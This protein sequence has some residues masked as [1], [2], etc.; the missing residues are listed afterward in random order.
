MRV[1]DPR[2][3]NDISIFSNILSQ[4]R[5]YYLFFF[6]LQ[7]TFGYLYRIGDLLYPQI[8]RSIC[9]IF[10]SMI[11]LCPI[12]PDEDE[13][14]FHAL[15][16][17]RNALLVYFRHRFP[18]YG[19]KLCRWW[20][21]PCQTRDPKQI[22]EVATLFWVIWNN[23]NDYVW[24]HRLKSAFLISRCASQTLAEWQQA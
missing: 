1:E 23:I 19:V 14:T 18:S 17:C 9:R 7:P 10:L 6:F 13:E 8:Y 20:P 11:A 15:V 16:Y 22:D 2:Y 3:F 4:Y 21:S 24:N 5:L 12:C